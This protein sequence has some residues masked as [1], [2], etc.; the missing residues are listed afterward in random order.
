MDWG[1]GAWRST[2]RF[3]SHRPSR[4][5]VRAIVIPGCVGFRRPEAFGRRLLGWD[6]IGR[7][8]AGLQLNASRP[9]HEPSCLHPQERARVT[10]AHRRRQGTP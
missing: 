8:D 5:R 6:R 1:A 2:L 9:G 4:R 10:G 3:R 7:V